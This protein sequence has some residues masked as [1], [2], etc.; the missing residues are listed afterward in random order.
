MDKA[1]IWNVTGGLA[2]H[3]A[4]DLLLMAVVDVE[5]TLRIYDNALNARRH[6]CC[7]PLHEHGNDQCLT[8]DYASSGLHVRKILW[9]SLRV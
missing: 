8:I 3:T 6:N 2:S 1:S 7:E 4:F 9:E 5:N